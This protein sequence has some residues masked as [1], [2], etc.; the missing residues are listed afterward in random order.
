MQKRPKR[1]YA[2][3]HKTVLV[4]VARQRNARVQG[5]KSSDEGLSLVLD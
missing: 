3:S 4:Y 2:V 1:L 5:P